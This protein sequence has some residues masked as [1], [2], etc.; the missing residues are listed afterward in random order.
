MRYV[1][2][3]VFYTDT[4][5]CYSP[6]YTLYSFACIKA[7]DYPGFLFSWTKLLFHVFYIYNFIWI[8][9]HKYK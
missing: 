7:N 1:E 6:I 8:T 5:Y 4:P 2:Y 3:T 9:I